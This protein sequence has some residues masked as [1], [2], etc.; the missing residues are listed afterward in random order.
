V[1]SPLVRAAFAALVLATIAAFFLTQQLKSETPVVLR[2]AVRPRAISPNGDGVRDRARVGFDLSAPATVTFSIIDGRGRVVRTLVDRRRLAGDR[3]YRYVWDGRDPRGRVVPDG[4][5]R[6]RIVRPGEDRPL[7]SI[8]TIQVDDRPPPVEL[9]SARPSVIAP[10]RGHPA[11]VRISYRGPRNVAPEFRVFRTDGGP[12][13]VVLRLRGDRTRS[14]LWNGFVR[15]HPAVDGDYTFSVTVR[16]EAGNRAVAPGAIPTRAVA[17]PGTGVDVR[18]LTLSGP[19]RALP[20]GGVARFVVGPLPRSVRF[21]LTRLGSPRPLLA[22]RRRA[23]TL[24]VHLPR[25]ARGGLYAVSVRYGAHSASWPLAVD[26]GRGGPLVVLPLLTWQGENPVDAE[27]DGFAETLR[28]ARSL[29][30]GS[31]FAGGAL[32]PDLLRRVAPVLRELDRLRL[33]YTLVTDLDVAD[34]RGRGAGGAALP[35]SERWATPALVRALRSVGRLALSG[36]FSPRPV[37]LAHGEIVLIAGRLPALP[38]GRLVP[39]G[40]GAALERT[41]RALARG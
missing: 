9:T 18:R 1:R 30:L 40:R 21:A 36:R 13:R 15:G 8:K 31:P 32:P 29:P 26:R 35:G 39:L 37:R 28:S 20:A 6:M 41:W 2:F 7:N 38:R 27:R 10:E 17:R 11:R 24:L 23:G 14:A 5:Y 25:R 12:T 34:G 4:V 16:D 33:G 3:K 19:V 22:G